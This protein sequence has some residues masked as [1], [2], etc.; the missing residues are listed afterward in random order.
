VKMLKC[1]ISEFAFALLLPS[2]ASRGDHQSYFRPQ[3]AATAESRVNNV[4][5]LNNIFQMWWLEPQ[6]KLWA[7]VWN[8][9]S[10]NAKMLHF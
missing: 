9:G 6:Y 8:S 5:V 4:E 3:L 1:F 7:E 2:L 10:E